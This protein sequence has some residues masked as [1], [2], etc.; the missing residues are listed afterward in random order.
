MRT[1]IKN[2]TVI[3]PETHFME[4]TNVI[5]EDGKIVH[6]GPITNGIVDH[7]IDASG[8]LVVPGLVDIHVHFRDPGFPQKET[9][10][11]GALSAAAGGFTTVVCMPNTK[12]SIDTVEILEYVL[13]TGLEQATVKVYSSAALTYGIEGKVLTE[14]ESLQQAG[15]VTFTDDGKTVM[16]PKLVYTAFR[17]AA[18]LDVPISS[19]CEDHQ[20]VSGGSLNQGKVSNQ[21]GDPGIPR[22]GEELIIARDILFAEETGARLHIQHVS[23]ARG[24][25]LIREAKARGVRVTGEGAP[26]HFSITD[27]QALVCGTLAKVNP[28]LRTREDVE[29]VIAGL[30]DGTLEAIATDHAPHTSEE[31]ARPLG[32]APFGMVGLETAV[33]LTFT[34]LVHSGRLA[35]TDAIAKLTVN[36]SNIMGL[37]SG[38]LAEGLDADITILDPQKEWTVDPEQFKSLSRNSP[39]AG[40][41][42]KGKAVLTMVNG[43]V[44]YDEML[45]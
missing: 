6:I 34:F 7:V 45:N 16:D 27:E 22:L 13:R 40:M 43:T 10:S 15:A 41:K 35:L 9:I 28:P 14:M 24:V 23:T 39:F 8:L 26:H 31:K 19:H 30:A 11:S 1:L 3:N 32:E 33:G 25:Q 44:V 12:P 36:P 21:L 29:A 4:I 20:L 2:G 38:R 37:P 42:L 17:K 5:I 18:E